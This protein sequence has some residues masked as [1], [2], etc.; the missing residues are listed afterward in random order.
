MTTEEIKKAA[1]EAY[2]IPAGT[3]N[4]DN[5]LQDY[6]AQ[7]QSAFICGADYI[8]ATFVTNAKEKVDIEKLE[9]E[10]YN[11]RQQHRDWG[12]ED[13]FDFFKPHLTGG[14]E[15]IDWDD[16]KKSFLSRIN[17]FTSHEYDCELLVGSL[18]KMVKEQ[19]QTSSLVSG[20]DEK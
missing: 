6:M 3:M 11:Q 14:K 10:F 15:G 4:P 17:S 2:P 20:G 9:T 16:L 8:L 1:E 18:I 13:I 19:I 12:S 5:E 7:V